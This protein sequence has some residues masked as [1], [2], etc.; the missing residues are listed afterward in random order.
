MV[1]HMRIVADYLEQIGQAELAGSVRVQAQQLSREK[2]LA[3][4]LRQLESLRE[5]VEQLQGELGVGRQVL[6][7]VQLAECTLNEKMSSVQSLFDQMDQAAGSP[8]VE[9][10]G[11]MF[12]LFETGDPA[13]TVL[14]KLREQGSVKVLARPTLMTLS[15]RSASMHI[16]GV[17][18]IP[19]PEGSGD[20]P[21]R[22]EKMGTILETLP[23]LKPDGTL[24]LELRLTVREIDQSRGIMVGDKPVPGLRARSLNTAVEM[25]PGQTLVLAG[26]IQNDEVQNDNDALDAKPSTSA[27]VLTVGTEVVAPATASRPAAPQPH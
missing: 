23:V 22:L 15:G 3:D 4:K 18:P 8:A 7:R 9:N 27:L 6:L 16:G 12:R 17:I 21:V 5:E 19:G 24:R 11:G 25:K 2:L 26:L 14:G 10:P 13:E 20:E 1:D